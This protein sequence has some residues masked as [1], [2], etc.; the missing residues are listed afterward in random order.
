[1]K[2]NK[3]CAD[4][5]SELA[6]ALS[7][8]K[9]LRSNPM[10]EKDKKSLDLCFAANFCCLSCNRRGKCKASIKIINTSIIHVHVSS[11]NKMY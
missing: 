2:F 6:M 4:F 1:M 8:Q 11:S 10:I 9:C 3:N 5:M 7:V